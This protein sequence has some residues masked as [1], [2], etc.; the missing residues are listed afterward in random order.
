MTVRLAS[1][2]TSTAPV[3]LCAKA[4]L[5]VRYNRGQ[6]ESRFIGALLHHPYNANR[7]RETT[8]GRQ[9]PLLPAAQ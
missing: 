1:A 5:Q 2:Q 8:R 4:L 3:R 7:A 6:E 9:Q